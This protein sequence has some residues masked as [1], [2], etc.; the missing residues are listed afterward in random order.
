MPDTQ[1][2]GDGHGGS[3]PVP[4]PTILTMEAMTRE[5]NGLQALTWVRLDSMDAAT[6]LRLSRLTEIEVQFDRHIAAVREVLEVRL[7]AVAQ[8][9]DL[10]F[11]ER[12][13]RTLDSARAG[14]DALAAALQAAKELV[15]SQGE[16]SAAAAVK[17]ETSF[18]KQ[19]DQIGV[20]IGTLQKAL[21]DRITSLEKT[22]ADRMSSLEAAF[23]DRLTEIKERQDRSEGT[24]VGR[25][26]QHTETRATMVAVL[27][28]AS[29]LLFGI[30]VA[31]AIYA[32]L[33]P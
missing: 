11:Q 16:S 22:F 20:I 14:A 5:V 13:V 12:D 8:E 6:E 17:S 26:G 27:S 25:V 24:I 18:T 23:T 30:S 29:A 4:D 10:R 32:A 33:K 21:D 28:V 9:V 3:R 19:I 15:G 1:M 2:I 7:D 31:V